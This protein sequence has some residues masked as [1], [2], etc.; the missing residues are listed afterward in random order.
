MIALVLDCRLD[1][2]ITSPKNPE[3]KIEP[4]G[5]IQADTV[6]DHPRNHPGHCYHI[7]FEFAAKKALY[8]QQLY[9]REPIYVG[10]SASFF[11]IIENT[12]GVKLQNCV[13]L[14]KNL[15]WGSQ[16]FLESH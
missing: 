5:C 3:R 9:R 13:C 16:F 4:R 15:G 14:S 6:V 11:F 2:N 10:T 8:K 7:N 1:L 12:L